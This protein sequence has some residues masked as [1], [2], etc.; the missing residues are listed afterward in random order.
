MPYS[1]GLQERTRLS[2]RLTVVVRL[3]APC[4]WV[5]F[6]LLAAFDNLTSSP[7]STLVPIGLCTAG[8]LWFRATSFQFCHVWAQEDGLLVVR[9]RRRSIIPYGAIRDA[10]QRHYFGFSEVLLNETSDFGNVI[11]FLPYLG[12]LI[13][14]VAE[15][16]AGVLIQ[17][18]AADSRKAGG[19]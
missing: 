3:V 6:C 2:S 14:F 13:P 19:A 9:G 16:P 11:L 7:L 1:S 18:R 12:Q 10:R 15:H 17:S 8:L 4:V 5:A